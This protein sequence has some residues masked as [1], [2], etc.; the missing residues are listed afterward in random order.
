[1]NMELIMDNG[2]LEALPKTISF[3]FEQ[4]KQQLTESL[5]HYASLVVTEDGIKD[6]KEDRAKLN[7]LR[8]ALE[9]ERKRVKKECLAPYQDFESKIKELVSLI[10]SP[11]SVIDTQLKEFEDKRKAEKKAD[12]IAAY[13]EV[14]GDLAEIVP[15]ESIWK[16]E[17]Y[18]KGVTLKKIRDGLERIAAR[19][20]ADLRVL[21]TV[22][23]EFSEV[24]K[25]KYLER[26]DLTEALNIRDSLRRRAKELL[27]YERQRA[28]AEPEPE[29]APEP[30]APAAPA[31]ETR[32]R[33]QFECFVTR[34]Q[35][36]ALAQYLKS[37][38]IE[39][40]RV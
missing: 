20:Q 2:A 39:Y 31:D 8:E 26:L 32:Y 16:D 14:F 29:A 40:R 19:A 10:D 38:N 34:A 11:I 9:T 35:A 33:L 17:W 12:I 36:S 15:L 5:T 25:M 22:E 28:E 27:A 4:L 37:N 3:N 7:K 30:E 24:V 21:D 18:N 23:S 1:M 13:Q 6:A